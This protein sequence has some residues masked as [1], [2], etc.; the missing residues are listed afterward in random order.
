MNN[1][2]ILNNPIKKSNIYKLK[3]VM[4]SEEGLTQF[5]CQNQH[6]KTYSLTGFFMWVGYITNDCLH[7]QWGHNIDC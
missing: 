1:F 3:H 4:S 2:C 5:K 7:H 6:Q